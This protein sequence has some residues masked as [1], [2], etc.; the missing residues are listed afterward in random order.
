MKLPN[1][2]LVERPGRKSLA[3]TP[4]GIL[5]ILFRRRRLIT[6]TFLGTAAGLLLAILIMPNSYQAEVKFLVERQ[7]L[8][9]VVSAEQKDGSAAARGVTQDE[10][11]SELELLMSREI[12]ERVV[13]TC[14][15]YEPKNPW[16]LAGMKLQLLK[17]IHLAPDQKTE[18]F[19]AVLNLEQSLQAV[20]MPSS[21]VI[22]VDY[23]SNTPQGAAEVL[24]KLSQFYI[25]K[26]ASIHRP[27]GTYEFFQQQAQQ[28]EKDLA[29]AEARLV[30]F[31]KSKG[32]VS[33]DLEKQITLQKM[34]EFDTALQQARAGIAETEQRVRS[35]TTLTA[36]AAPR[37]TTQVRTSEDSQLLSALKTNLLTLELKRTE[38][39]QKYEPTYRLVK[40][41]DMQIAQTRDAIEKAEK[42]AVREETTDRDAT[43]DW[44]KTELAKAKADMVGLQARAMV[45]QDTVR[46][47]QKKVLQLDADGTTQAALLRAVKAGQDNYVSFRQ[48]QEEAGVA[49]A[50]SNKRILNVGVAQATAVPWVPYG[51][52]LPLK[53]LLG[54][55]LA[56]FVGVAAAFGADYLDPSFRTPDEV[57][58]ELS[59][60][61]LA[62]IPIN[63]SGYSHYELSYANGN[64]NGH[65]SDNGHSRGH[66]VPQSQ[67]EGTVRT[68]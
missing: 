53:L 50:L 47:M 13:V 45:T 16:S 1:K 17:A 65:S 25:E 34:N 24:N 68:N 30:E 15:L 5:A 29:A 4:R 44:A 38:M 46:S 39:L 60:P 59:I 22:K 54:L 66:V 2:N 27:T 61:V 41:T 62:A 26:N 9:P 35:L 14:H 40:E 33:A 7:R 52:S 19:N 20:I 58:D 12:L 31:N 56:G 21:D 55:I 49:D 18:I 10:L 6:L 43:Y 42:S 48:K 37:V 8:D 23:N 57:S 32:V 28:Y 67:A 51:P 64:G 3:L 63:L 36:T 11:N